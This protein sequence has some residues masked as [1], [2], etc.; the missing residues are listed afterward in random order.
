MVPHERRGFIGLQRERDS[1]LMTAFGFYWSENSRLVLAI[2]IPSLIA[3][4]NRWIGQ[5]LTMR[6]SGY[7]E[8]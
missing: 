8:L 7:Q 2:R 6:E 4:K 5:K 3:R 1:G